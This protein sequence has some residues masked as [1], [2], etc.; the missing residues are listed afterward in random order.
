MRTLLIKNTWLDD[1]LLPGG[2][3]LPHGWGN[4]YVVVPKTHFAHGM[5]YYALED[6][7]PDLAVHGG[8]TYAASA[9]HFKSTGHDLNSEDW[10]FGFDTCHYMDSLER[11]PKEAVEKETDYLLGQLAVLQHSLFPERYVRCP[12]KLKK[13]IHNLKKRRY[14]SNKPLT[15][16]QNRTKVRLT[17]VLKQFFT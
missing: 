11:W 6:L 15:N 16:I 10:V 5:S 9:S 13:A 17:L 7:L 1:S 8:L 3:K 14:W 2:R 12:R 4:G